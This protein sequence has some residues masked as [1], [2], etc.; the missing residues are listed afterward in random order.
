LWSAYKGR[1]ATD[2]SWPCSIFDSA[3]VNTTR[4]EH[5]WNA[6]LESRPS[7]P[8]LFRVVIKFMSFR[9]FISCIVFVFCLIFGFIGPTCLVKG[10]ISY[11]EKPPID[12]DGSLNYMYGLYLIFGILSVEISRVLM[13][14]ATWATSY[15][16]GIR[17]RGAVL[18]LLYK[19]LLNSKSLRD[20]NPA[21]V[22]FY[23]F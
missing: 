23:H 1:I 21:E 14:G 20:K 5:L 17:V 9:L 11:S 6:E 16:T 19:S 15:R 7:N 8:S 4:L 2:Q 12:E 22:R 10:L 13:Y 18:S 3:N